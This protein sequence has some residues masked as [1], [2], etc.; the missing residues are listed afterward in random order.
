MDYQ[1]GPNWVYPPKITEDVGE[2]IL[3]GEALQQTCEKKLE[4]ILDR[5]DRITNYYEEACALIRKVALEEKMKEDSIRFYLRVESFFFLHEKS[6]IQ[7]WIRYWTRLYNKAGNIELPKIEG[8][9]SEEE[10]EMA[11]MFPI[12][13]MYEGNLRTSYNQLIG[14]CPFHEDSSPSFVIYTGDNH[15]HCFG[16]AAHGDAIDFYQRRNGVDFKTAVK[17][18]L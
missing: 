5:L 4:Q 6:Y 9:V 3:Y 12:Q 18:L 11:K 17:G 1:D 13:D 15:Y 2:L 10:I 7:S 16:C 8:D 14:S